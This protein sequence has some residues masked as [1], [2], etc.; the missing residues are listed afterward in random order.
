MA[1]NNVRVE[2]NHAG[3]GQLL[4]SE[5]LGEKLGQL[6]ESYA[7]DGWESDTKQMGTRVIASIYTT[8]YDVAGE[9]LDTHALVG[10]LSS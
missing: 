8:D 7:G 4:K 9:E 5:E 1:K 3:I 10:R 6:A 2:L